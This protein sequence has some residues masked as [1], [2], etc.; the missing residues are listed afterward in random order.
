MEVGLILG[1]DAFE[2]Q[3]SLD[4]KIGTRSEPFAALTELRLVVSGPKTGKRR[5]NVC[6]FAITEDVKV[7]ENIQT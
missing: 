1:Q 5:R 4:Y 2:L 6:H 7:A 3:R